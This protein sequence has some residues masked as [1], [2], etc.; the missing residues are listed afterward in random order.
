MYKGNI[1]K[2]KNNSESLYNNINIDKEIVERVKV[3]KENA[4]FAY[5]ELLPLWVR[6]PM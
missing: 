2:Y 4:F 3:S 1:F 5:E 6:Q